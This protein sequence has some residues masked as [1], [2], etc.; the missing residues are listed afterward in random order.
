MKVRKPRHWIERLH[1]TV[2]GYYEHRMYIEERGLVEYLERG[3]W[4]L[5]DFEVGQLLHP[6]LDMIYDKVRRPDCEAST[7]SRVL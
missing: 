5:S 1:V 2:L 6:G 3:I 4:S 7:V